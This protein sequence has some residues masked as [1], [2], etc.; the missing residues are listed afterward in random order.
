MAT[1]AAGN[2]VAELLR[3]LG[4]V[5]EGGQ[6][7]KKQ[8]KEDPDLMPGYRN[9]DSAQSRKLSSTD[10][11]QAFF[12]QALEKAA[13]ARTTKM[14]DR[15]VDPYEG[16]PAKKATGKTVRPISDGYYSPSTILAELLDPRTLPER[17]NPELM[18]SSYRNSEKRTDDPQQAD[19]IFNEVF[20]NLF[21]MMDQSRMEDDAQ[22]K[23]ESH[24]ATL[25]EKQQRM[26]IEAAKAQ[27]DGVVT[28]AELS[29]PNQIA[30]PQQPKSPEIAAMEDIN[31]KAAAIKSITTQQTTET[32]SDP[33]TDHLRTQ[34][35]DA[36]QKMG[37]EKHLEFSPIGGLG[38]LL[39]LPLNLIGLPFGKEFGTELL[40]GK[41]PASAQAGMYAKLLYQA[42][43]L[44]RSEM[45]DALQREKMER[46]SFERLRRANLPVG[47]ASYARGSASEDVDDIIATAIDM[48][49]TLQQDVTTQEAFSSD[50]PTGIGEMFDMFDNIDFAQQ[51]IGSMTDPTQLDELQSAATMSAMGL[52]EKLREYMVNGGT[53]ETLMQQIMMAQD[54]IDKKY[55][56]ELEYLPGESKEGFQFRAMQK[57]TAD[58]F[59][60]KLQKFGDTAQEIMKLLEPEVA[61][62]IQKQVEEKKKQDA[63]TK[64]FKSFGIYG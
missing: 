52:Q 13:D 58:A 22:M 34:L 4:N 30:A 3:A 43:P 17:D 41:M 8:S 29:L 21:K 9:S 19:V 53:P 61:P 39:G 59:T 60:K 40:G 23:R 18:Q 51:N 62:V 56:Q 35:H 16:M 32:P 24:E 5:V 49:R 10:E 37:D 14:G 47:L 1:K 46:N 54:A 44:V 42:S 12:D 48:R 26:E 7:P 36:V 57:A 2:Y 50:S 33:L 6:D 11:L 38:K 28:N 63:K 31:A 25:A 55:Q 15:A 45:S 20:D 64:Q 27:N